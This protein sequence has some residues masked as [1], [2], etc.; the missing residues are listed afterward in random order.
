VDHVGGWRPWTEE[1][2]EP[3]VIAH[4]GVPRRFDR[5]LRTPGLNEHINRVQFGVD[6]VTWPSE[7]RWPDRTYVDSLDLVVGGERFELH[8]ARGETDDATWLWAPTR[9]VL[10]TG[11]F[12]ISCV[13]NCGNPQKVQRYPE[14]WAEA[15]EAMSALGA[16]VLLPGHGPAITG[17]SEVRTALRD[18]A[19]YLRSIVD[20]T[21]EALNRGLRA[22]EVVASVTVPPDL[23]AKPYLQPIYDRPEFIVRNVIRLH[24][25][26]WDGWPADLLPAPAPSRAHEIVA[27]AGGV[28]RL[29]DRARALADT[30]LPLACH[31]AEWAATAEPDSRPALECVRDLFTRRA[32]EEPSLMGQGIFRHAVRTA[33]A[34]LDA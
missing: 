21:L 32:A 30:D 10:C 24:G 34:A 23:A 13:P 17:A 26:W 16:E 15:L 11:D 1:G 14:E 8:H 27:L 4:E 5:Y 19:A 31:L 25:G 29:V 7:F 18:A 22:E 6:N 12:W 33:E 20:Q 2:A 28:E 9:G 3:T